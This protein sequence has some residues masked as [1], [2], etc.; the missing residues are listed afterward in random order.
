MAMSRERKRKAIAKK[1]GISVSEVTDSMINSYSD[2]S[3]AGYDSGSSYS[4][5]GGC[6][7]GGGE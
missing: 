3:L 5:S 1:R 7:G 4:D 2:A 6:S